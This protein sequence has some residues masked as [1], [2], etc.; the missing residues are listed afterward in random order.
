MLHTAVAGR[1][2][3]NPGRAIRRARRNL[4]QLRK[5]HPSG[6]GYHW[7]ETWESVLDSGPDEI[8]RTLTSAAPLAVELRQNSPF[9]GVLTQQERTSVLRAFRDSERS[10]SA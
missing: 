5:A 10:P 2:A 8:L 7:L 4:E 6:A 9:A 1:V 3:A